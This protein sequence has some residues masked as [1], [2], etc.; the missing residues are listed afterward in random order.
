MWDRKI[1]PFHLRTT[2]KLKYLLICITA[3]FFVE[4]FGLYVHLFEKDFDT[5][6]DYPMSGNIIPYAEQMK[7]SEKPS[8]PPINEYNFT[9]ISSSQEKCMDKTLPLR[10][11]IIIKSAMEHFARRVA[12]RN[13]WG[14]EKRFSDVGI[15]TVFLLGKPKT[16][17]ATLEREIERERVNYHDI[18]Q[19]DFVDSYFNNTIKTMLGFKW[20]VKYCPNAKFYLFVDDDY[21]IS[22]KNVLRFVRNPS[23]YP[24]YVEEQLASIR[25]LTRHKR[26]INNIPILVSENKVIKYKINNDHFGEDLYDVKNTSHTMRA[27]KE[28]N[29]ELSDDALLYSGKDY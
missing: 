12:I 10:L 3:I 2:R 22:I 20:A 26:D 9:Y 19:I 16:Y 23:H 17:E 7:N 21:Y 14:F 11:V 27:L 8:L 18:V 15:R 6:F 29:Y 24:E 1:Q 4:Y 28:F 13:S 25:K 5:T